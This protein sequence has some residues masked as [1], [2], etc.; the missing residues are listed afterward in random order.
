M[1]KRPNI[2]FSG[3]TAAGKTTH[4]KILA[5]QLGYRYVAAIDIIL[6]ILKMEK[7]SERIWF[8]EMNSIEKAREGDRV[9]IELDARLKKIA[10]TEDGIVFDTWAMGWIYDGSMIRIWLESDLESRTRKCFVSQG[11]EKRLDLAGC[12]ELIQ[13]KDQSTRETFARLHDFDLFKDKDRYDAIICNTDLIPRATNECSKE[14]IAKFTPIVY[15]VAQHF[16][17]SIKTEGYDGDMRA[18]SLGEK[19]GSMIRRL[20][21]ESK[22]ST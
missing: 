1:D 13:Q 11:D 12:K 21:S 15:D 6:Q 17:N 5:D 7:S 22:S 18:R 4:A 19:Y 3:L 14:G 9:D 20:D 8:S 2:A 16:I 10:D